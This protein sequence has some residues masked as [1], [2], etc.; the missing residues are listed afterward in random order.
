MAFRDIL[1]HLWVLDDASD[2]ES[3]RWDGEQGVELT[4]AIASARG[5]RSL[6]SVHLGFLNNIVGHYCRPSISAV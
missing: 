2:C 5:P 3:Q 4:T 6:C 1:L